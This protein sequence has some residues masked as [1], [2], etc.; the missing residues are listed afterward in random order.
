MA[1]TSIHPTPPPASTLNVPPSKPWNPRTITFSLSHAKILASGETNPG[2]W[3]PIDGQSSL[4]FSIE[5]LPDKMTLVTKQAGSQEEEIL[6]WSASD[7]IAVRLQV[8]DLPEDSSQSIVIL[9]IQN[10]EKQRIDMTL[11]LRASSDYK[12]EKL[13]SLQDRL[14]RICNEL[15]IPHKI[16]MKGAF[17]IPLPGE[18]PIIPPKTPPNYKPGDSSTFILYPERTVAPRASTSTVTGKGK[19]KGKGK[20][21]E[22]GESGVQK[23]DG[24]KR[25]SQSG[26]EKEAEETDESEYKGG[27]DEEEDE[28]KGKKKPE[29]SKQRVVKKGKEK[30]VIEVVSRGNGNGLKKS[31]MKVKK[32]TTTTKG[33]NEAKKAKKVKPGYV[34]ETVTE[35]DTDEFEEYS[36]NGSATPQ[37]RRKKPEPPVVT[38]PKGRLR[39]QSTVTKKVSY[40]E[41]GDSFEEDEGGDGQ[42]EYSEKGAEDEE[43]MDYDTQAT[44]SRKLTKSSRSRSAASSTPVAKR[45]RRSSSSSQPPNRS[46]PRTMSPDIL[47]APIAST[48]R[49]F[50]LSPEVQETIDPLKRQVDAQETRLDALSSFVYSPNRIGAE[51]VSTGEGIDWTNGDRERDPKEKLEFLTSAYT[52][53]R[54]K[55]KLYA[56]EIQQLKDL[57]RG[58]SDGTGKEKGKGKE[59]AEEGDVE[60]VSRST[61]QESSIS[62]LQNRLVALENSYSNLNE[63]LQSLQATA[64]SAFVELHAT[65]AS[66]FAR[67]D[68]LGERNAQLEK[69]KEE[70]RRE[71]RKVRNENDLLERRREEERKGEAEERKRL[72]D[73]VN[74]IEENL[75]RLMGQST[76]NPQA[77]FGNSGPSFNTHNASA[78]TSGQSQ[79]G[80][81]NL[82][83]ASANN[84]DDSNSPFQQ[85]FS[86]PTLPQDSDSSSPNGSTRA[87]KRI[88]NAPNT[89]L[90]RRRRAVSIGGPLIQNYS[91]PPR[92]PSRRGGGRGGGKG[93][94][95]ATPAKTTRSNRSTRSKTVDPPVNSSDYDEPSTSSLKRPSKLQQTIPSRTVRTRLSAGSEPVVPPSESAPRALPPPQSSNS[96]ERYHSD[97][98]AEEEEIFGQLSEIVDQM[99]PD[100][101]SLFRLAKGARD[102]LWDMD[103]EE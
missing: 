38:S 27:S 89:E 42:S 33:G 14:K 53:L 46:R 58:M 34:E 16:S 50:E 69:E 82:G 97:E 62:I 95:S 94:A 73:K 77:V 66:A 78:S 65:T 9:T 64:S 96:H 3:N 85:P 31:E 71:E 36:E 86:L 40:V 70:F 44:S 55:M 101:A 21:K 74:R 47:P 39:R 25:K 43:E 102:E 93:R 48:S 81:S 57:G 45:R 54:A 5:A 28:G 92:A 17:A 10:R 13:M 91:P 2:N 35:D 18:E 6:K 83:G 12:Q 103:E 59:R 8:E 7:L 4:Q 41:K 63:T 60:M 11:D 72:E 20:P 26:K 23:Q 49:L 32:P 67:I 51:E 87:S 52:D 29:K 76:I 1:S 98:A 37:R 15:R 68:E 79:L 61:P 80:Q 30:A 88:A 19:G 75:N 100:Q 22:N 56:V 90:S 24:K 84:R 99:D